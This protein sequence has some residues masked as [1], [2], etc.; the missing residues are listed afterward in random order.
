MYELRYKIEDLIEQNA[1]DFEISKVIK[2][3]IKEYLNSLDNIFKKRQ[4]KDFLVKHTKKIDEFIIIAYKYVLRKYFKDYLPFQSQIPI[5][6]CALGS[7][8]REQLCI[9]SDIDIMIVYDE[10]EGY[11]IDKII[12]SLL[13]IFWDSGLRLGH[14]THDIKDIFEASKKDITIKTAMIEA[15]FLCGSKIAWMKTSRELNKIR[16]YNQ[17]EFILA[18]R[19]YNRQRYKKF[20]LNMEPNIKDGVGGLRDANSL[21]WIANILYGVRNTKELIPKYISEN[22]HKEFRVALEFLFRVRSALHLSSKRKN[23]IL[24]LENI[25]E[26]AKLLGFKDNKFKTA[27]NQLV[28][29][30]LHSLWTIKVT[31]KIL[32]K[33]LTKSI[34]FDKKNIAI[35]KSCLFQKQIYICKN[36]IFTTLNKR[37]DSYINMLKL[38]LKLMSENFDF[39]ISYINYLKRTKILDKTSKEA[40]RLKRELFFKPYLYNTFYA[41]Y[42]ANILHEIFTPFKKILNLPQFDGYHK[43]PVDIHSIYALYILENIEDSLIKNLFLELKEEEKALLRVVIFLHDIGKGRREDHRIIGAI[44]L[45]HQAKKLGF[46][47]HLIDIGTT[48][49]KYHTQMSSVASK[50]DIYS[51]KVILSFV[52]KLRDKKILKML[53]IL[54]YCDM[55]A[56]NE[57]IYSPFFASLLKELYFISLDTFEKEELIDETSRRLKKERSLKRNSEFLKLSKI[58]QKNILSINSNIFFIKYKS[59]KIIQI[60]KWVESLKAKEYDY[61][62]DISSHLSITIIR[63]NELNL[64]YLLGKLSSL[65]VASMDIFKLF[66]GVKYFKIDFLENIDKSELLYIE[67]IVKNSFD[68]TKNISYKVPTIYKKELLFDCNH[69]KSYAKMAL[70]TKDQRAIIAHIV[71]IFDHFGVDIQTAKI[72]TIKKKT[73]NLFLIEKNGKFCDNLEKIKEK[74]CVA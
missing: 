27:Q 42:K 69:S 24:N 34:L 56:V 25:P 9:Y 36:T 17:K 23:D 8:G 30:T 54:T 41:F 19:E 1:D 10:I 20:Q 28:Y 60:S 68:M 15:R 16:K 45:K 31:S 35:L 6:I 50:E 53:Y 12:S 26:V 11:N 2:N 29:H 14:R 67:E 49:V 22:E 39:D 51:E 57:K 37:G 52:S 13:H 4:G 62:I 66:N 5:A 64:G 3:S 65:N 72:Q 70:Y 48:L 74:I 47:D 7:Y 59:A 38:S 73:H 43:Y 55:R 71:S 18:L 44:I 61:K 33:K 21:F 63:K 40:Y 58:L 32:I 46:K